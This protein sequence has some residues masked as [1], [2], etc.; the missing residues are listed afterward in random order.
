MNF[1]NQIY[2]AE[3]KTK[4]ETIQNSNPDLWNFVNQVYGNIVSDMTY[5]DAVDTELQV[6]VSLIQMDALPQVSPLS[7]LYRS[8]YLIEE[9]MNSF[10]TIS[11]VLKELV[12]QTSK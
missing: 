8:F 2:G 5:V 10:R 1:F 12:L 7:S 4:Q 9:F 6:I 3:S 11:W